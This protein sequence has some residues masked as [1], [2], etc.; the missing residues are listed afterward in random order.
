M[1]CQPVERCAILSFLEYLKQEHNGYYAKCLDA[2][3]RIVN[4]FGIRLVDAYPVFLVPE[5][6]DAKPEEYQLDVID[7]DSVTS[8][9]SDNEEGREF[10]ADTADE[11][12]SKAAEKVAMSF[13]NVKR[14]LSD[15]LK[16]DSIFGN[17]GYK[18]IEYV[19]LNE[20]TVK[21][22][23]VI[24]PDTPTIDDN[25]VLTTIKNTKGVTVLAIKA[26]MTD[27]EATPL[28]F[29]FEDNR[30]LRDLRGM[31]NVHVTNF[32]VMKSDG[33]H[34]TTIDGLLKSTYSSTHYRAFFNNGNPEGY[35]A[36]VAETIDVARRI[37]Q[38]SSL[39]LVHIE[40]DLKNGQTSILYC[41][42]LDEEDRFSVPLKE[43][44]RVERHNILWRSHHFAKLQWE[45]LD[46]YNE[47]TEAPESDWVK[48]RFVADLVLLDMSRFGWAPCWSTPANTPLEMEDGKA[49]TFKNDLSEF[50]P[51]ST[52]ANDAEYNSISSQTKSQWRC[53]QFMHDR[54]FRKLRRRHFFR[55]VMEVKDDSQM[56]SSSG[57]KIWANGYD[58]DTD[59]DTDT[60]KKTFLESIQK[61]TEADEN[62]IPAL[63]ICF[64]STQIRLR[65]GLLQPFR[66]QGKT[67]HP[68]GRW[69]SENLLSGT[70]FQ[71]TDTIRRFKFL[72]LKAMSVPAHETLKRPVVEW[73]EDCKKVGT[74]LKNRMMATKLIVDNTVT[75]RKDLVRAFV[76]HANDKIVIQR[77]LQGSV[78]DQTTGPVSLISTGLPCAAAIYAYDHPRLCARVR[79]RLPN[80]ADRDA[81][82][83]KLKMLKPY[84]DATDIGNINEF[85]GEWEDV[86]NTPREETFFSERSNKEKMY[87]IVSLY[88]DGLLSKRFFQVK[89]AF[90]DIFKKWLEEGRELKKHKRQE[91]VCDS[92]LNHV[93]SVALKDGALSGVLSRRLREAER[94]QSPLVFADPGINTEIFMVTEIDISNISTMLT[95]QKGPAV[96]VPADVEVDQIVH[97]LQRICPAHQNPSQDVQDAFKVETGEDRLIVTRLDWWVG[98]AKGEIKSYEEATAVVPV[99]PYRFVD[100]QLNR[101]DADI[102]DTWLVQNTAI[103][104]FESASSAVRSMQRAIRDVDDTLSQFSNT[105]SVRAFKDAS[106]LTQ[107]FSDEKFLELAPMQSL[108]RVCRIAFEL[109]KGNA[110]KVGEGGERPEPT[111]YHDI[112]Q[113]YVSESSYLV[114]I[115]YL[116]WQYLNTSSPMMGRKRAAN[117]VATSHLD[118]LLAPF[119]HTPVQKA[120]EGRTISIT[121]SNQ[122][123]LS[124]PEYAIGVFR[125]LQLRISNA[126]YAMNNLRTIYQNADSL[127]FHRRNFELVSQDAAPYSKNLA[128]LVP[129]YNTRKSALLV[130]KY[131][132]PKEFE[133]GRNHRDITNGQTKFIADANTLAVYRQVAALYMATTVTNLKSMQFDIL[134]AQRTTSPMLRNIM[135]E[136]AMIAE[137]IRNARQFLRCMQGASGVLPR[138]KHG[139]A[140]KYRHAKTA[141]LILASKTQ[142]ILEDFAE[143]HAKFEDAIRSYA[144][145]ASIGVTSLES[146]KRR[147]LNAYEAV[148]AFRRGY[149]RGVYGLLVYLAAEFVQTAA[150]GTLRQETSALVRSLFGSIERM[151]T[152]NAFLLNRANL[153]TSL[154]LDMELSTMFPNIEVYTAL[155]ARMHVNGMLA[156]VTSAAPFRD[157]PTQIND[158]LYQRSIRESMGFDSMNGYIDKYGRIGKFH[159][160]LPTAED[161]FTRGI[162]ETCRDTVG[163][164]AKETKKGSSATTSRDQ[165]EV[166]TNETDMEMDAESS[167]EGSPDEEYYDEGGEQEDAVMW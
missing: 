155:A 144:D 110:S 119:Q 10:M 97:L 26:E 6:V 165:Y 100:A 132:F 92:A 37:N 88:Y 142:P 136:M 40:V 81:V 24:A 76:S 159:C 35:S 67:T 51:V 22:L 162:E 8:K 90:K 29:D 120:N 79:I 18:S 45:Y 121:Y 91:F 131:L 124:V 2:A 75:D 116:P 147:F 130:A 33:A 95:H 58:V 57:V 56:L 107:V 11:I 36:Y 84:E 59:V 61:Y 160:L 14:T 77:A 54:A 146:L 1:V 139:Y 44:S 17:L 5:D 133:L 25:F 94:K 71:V 55:S 166:Y 41:K 140:T 87:K 50:K 53:T 39:G 78:Y 141:T 16:A 32:S 102:S 13:K 113:T 152:S 4:V 42:T 7:R 46:V 73:I 86:K 43:F 49:R 105:D 62:D 115:D 68:I 138:M 112:A 38:S 23:E 164:T 98:D 167:D 143:N 74:R 80:E 101:H 20:R 83:S 122:N 158:H 72:A 156:C 118:T 161:V 135:T 153:E 111:T 65:E 60:V 108:G 96:Y 28:F 109:L 127:T 150:K 27:S 93:I 82:L 52:R 125:M 34:G 21:L 117:A 163:R 157:V 64:T 63:C 154:N 114:A 104:P 148:R 134:P 66:N 128:D 30:D 85:F 9:W 126:S 137:G 99:V 89:T 129:S 103:T 19:G 123:I 31:S 70:Y 15:F 69:I 48:L 47:S 3:S 12:R 149:D 151:M 106:V 145:M